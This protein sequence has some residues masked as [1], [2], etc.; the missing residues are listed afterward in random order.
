MSLSA[1]MKQW[2]PIYDFDQICS[3]YL[4]LTNIQSCYDIK[5]KS[6]DESLEFT[7]SF[8][9]SIVDRWYKL[10]NTARYETRL[11]MS[12]LFQQKAKKLQKKGSFPKP[13]I[14]KLSNKL[15]NAEQ[16]EVVWT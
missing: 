4:K 15:T 11:R 12:I 14:E 16:R 13:D 8:Q 5:Y 7:V 10:A 1:K 2:D 9:D 6:I 3:D